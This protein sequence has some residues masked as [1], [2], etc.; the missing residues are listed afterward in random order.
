MLHRTQAD[1]AAAERAQGTFA[2]RERLSREI[3]DTLAQGFASVVTL[4]RAAESALGRGDLDAVRQRLALL[5]QTAVENL[6]RRA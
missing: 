1:L 4:S 2:E 3:H 6:P 5:E